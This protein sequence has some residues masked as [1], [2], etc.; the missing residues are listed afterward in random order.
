MRIHDSAVR[1]LVTCVAATVLAS[2]FAASWPQ[3]GA[4][5]GLLLESVNAAAKEFCNADLA[6]I[7][8]WAAA[9]HGMVF[10]YTVGTRAGGHDHALL[11]G[12]RRTDA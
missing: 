11:V 8:L 9:R 4:P 3:W 6:R 12:R 2:L 1:L 10:R 7:A 5:V